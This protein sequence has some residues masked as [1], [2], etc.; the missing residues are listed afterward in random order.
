[1]T[2]SWDKKGLVF[3]PRRHANLPWMAE[4]AQAPCVVHHDGFL[5]V[6]F[7]SRPPVDAS[8]QYKS[9]TAWVDLSADHQFDI[10]GTANEPILPL[11]ERGCFDE[12]G[13]Y[14][15]S[16]IKRDGKY[17]AY[18]AGW[19]RCDSVPFNV[20]IGM[21]ESDNDGVTFRKAGPGP[22]LSYSPDEPF[23]ISGPKIR[24]FNGQLYLFYIA[25]KK[26]ILDQGKPE[27]VYRIRMAG[28]TDGIHW[29]KHNA[30]LIHTVLEPD[31]CQASPDVFFHNGKYHMFFCYRRSTNYRGKA[32]GYRIGY[33]SSTDLVEWTREDE[34]AGITVSDEGW[35]SEMVAYP[36]VFQLDDQI[37][38]FYLGNSVGKDGFGLA[39][40]S[41]ALQ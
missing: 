27:P 38:M 28:S 25:G 34:K 32:G 4:F 23:I 10:V 31:E 16:V 3:S 40:L 9:F 17:L 1:M 13:I 29:E 14:P 2:F 24:D 33:A 30:D 15:A 20:A 19:T 26:W 41:G 21:A 35:D 36:H 12:F 22:V 11:G 18:Y 39:Q 5:R 8:G 6:Y 37:Y 7:S